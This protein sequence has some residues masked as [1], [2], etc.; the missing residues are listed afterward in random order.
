MIII[1]LRELKYSY[2]KNIPAAWKKKKKK[3]KEEE[4]VLCLRFEK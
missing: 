4:T 2:K 3:K 1:H